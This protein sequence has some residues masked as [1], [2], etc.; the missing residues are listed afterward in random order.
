MTSSTNCTRRE[1]S[2]VL[3]AAGAAAAF[4][5][6]AM[7]R[8]PI[9]TNRCSGFLWPNGRCTKRSL[10]ARWI[11]WILPAMR[12]S[13]A[14]KAW[15][16]SIS[17]SRTR[18]RT[19][20]YIAQMKRRAEDVGVHSLLIMCDGEGRL[21]DPSLQA[22]NKPWKIT[23]SGWKRPRNSAVIRFGSMRPAR[24]PTRISSIGPPM[25]SGR[26]G[27]CCFP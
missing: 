26:D 24:V 13:V 14:S 25:A 5:P 10:T 18:R 1:F 15:S 19:A 23:T 17:S 2:Q 21:G 8:Q 6:R 16:T 11:T 22:R 4:P 20:Q 7:P 9:R 27:V 12:N 3:L